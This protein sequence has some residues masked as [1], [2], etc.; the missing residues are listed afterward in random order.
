MDG[1]AFRVMPYPGPDDFI[2]YKRIEENIFTKFQYRNLDNPDVFLNRNIQGLLQNYRSAF[3]R[4]ANYYQNVGEK[5][6]AIT[7]LDKM[8]EVM[9]ESVV[10]LRDYR[11]SLNF[12][13]L[14][15]DA[16]RPEELERRLEAALA[17]PGLSAMDKMLIAQ[18]F[19]YELQ[20][21]ERAEEIVTKIIDDHPDF[22]QAYAWLVGQYS[23]KGQN[24]KSVELLEKWLALRPGDASAERQLASLRKMAEADSVLKASE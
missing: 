16:G 22:P 5:D 15:K 13:R 20:K 6:K 21:V 24:A 23:Q 19:S 8:E 1:L 12:G 7:A 4:L 10:P 17:E 9:P 3:V 11:L 18:T 14:Y 2:S